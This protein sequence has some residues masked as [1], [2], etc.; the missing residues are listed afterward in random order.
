MVQVILLPWD[1]LFLNTTHFFIGIETTA[2][3][4]IVVIGYNVIISTK[5]MQLFTA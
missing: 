5:Q 3:D 1:L 2:A 4:M